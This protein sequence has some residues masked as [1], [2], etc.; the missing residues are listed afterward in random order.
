MFS[1]SSPK[2]AKKILRWK[3]SVIFFTSVSLDHFRGVILQIFVLFDFF[4]IFFTIFEPRIRVLKQKGKNYEK[5]SFDTFLNSGS[6]F[7]K[8]LIKQHR[9]V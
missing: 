2:T 8:K 4:S 6:I 3:T 7:G 1:D 5:I 9:Y